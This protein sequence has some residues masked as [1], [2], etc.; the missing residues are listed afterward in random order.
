ML[1]YWIEA[2]PIYSKE[3]V[4][5]EYLFPTVYVQFLLRYCKSLSENHQYLTESLF[6]EFSNLEKNC[7]ISKTEDSEHFLTFEQVTSNSSIP[8]YLYRTSEH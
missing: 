3:I 7:D 5:Y 8:L 2:C 6:N 4:E 1:S